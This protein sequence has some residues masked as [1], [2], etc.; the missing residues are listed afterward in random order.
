MLVSALSPQQ[1]YGHPPAVMAAMK[2]LYMAPII[3]GIME[4]KG[5][6]GGMK[7]DRELAMGCTEPGMA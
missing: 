2:G 4:G 7:A 1:H 6:K 5:M 3:M